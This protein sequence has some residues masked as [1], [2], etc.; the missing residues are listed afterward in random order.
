VECGGEGRSQ[1]EID[2]VFITHMVG[3]TV[4]RRN[5]NVPG[6]ENKSLGVRD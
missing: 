3:Y 4:V 1:C 6:R 5:A 2:C